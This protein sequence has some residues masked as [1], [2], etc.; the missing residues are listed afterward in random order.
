MITIE[1][2]MCAATAQLDA[3]L[4]ALDCDD[5]GVVEIAPDATASAS[6][7][8]P[9]ARGAPDARTPDGLP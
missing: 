3:T 7:S 9:D 4:V 6:I 1:C 2:P 5:C 8:P